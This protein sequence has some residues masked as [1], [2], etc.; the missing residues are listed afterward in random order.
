MSFEN[1]FKSQVETL[2]RKL[3]IGFSIILL[4]IFSLLYVILNPSV[5]ERQPDKTDL[6]DIQEV[7]EDLIENGIHV[8]TGFVD[9]DGLTE[10]IQNC[11]NCHSAKL[12]TQNRMSKEGWVA[13][14]RWMQETQNLWDLGNNEEIIVNYLATN[15]APDK[16]GRRDI[17]TD[18]D[19]YTLE[20]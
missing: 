9:G 19:W 16:K 1:R 12:V 6:V 13:T 18:I 17:L 8:A 2:Y 3:I 14:I 15:Y 5:F 11:T 20:E 10:V 4:C 7:E